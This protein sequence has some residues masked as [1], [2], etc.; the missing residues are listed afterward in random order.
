MNIVKSKDNFDKD[1]K[2]KC[3]NCN[4]YRLIVK[5][6]LKLKQEKET[7]KSYKYKKI[8]YLV[9]GCRTEQKMKN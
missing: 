6:Y 3:F 2:L 8:E 5:D 9:K 1:R 7:R 4:I